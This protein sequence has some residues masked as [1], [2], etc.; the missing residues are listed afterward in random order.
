MTLLP[1]PS[2]ASALIFIIWEIV[3]AEKKQQRMAT[4]ETNHDHGS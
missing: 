4:S 3:K 1:A 2:G